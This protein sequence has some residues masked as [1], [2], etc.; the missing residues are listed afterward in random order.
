MFLKQNPQWHKKV[1]LALV[2]V[3]SRVGI[4]E[5][6]ETKEHIEEAVETHQRQV[7][8]AGLGTGTIRRAL[9]FEQVVAL[10][11]TSQVALVTPLRD[12]MNLIAKEYVASR[13]DNAGV[14]ILSE[15]AGAAK[16]LGEALLI[17]PN[18]TDEMAEAIKQ[19]LEMP[20]AEQKLRNAAMQ[21]RLR[22][23]NVVAWAKDFV[24]EINQTCIE[25]DMLVSKVPT[26]AEEEEML[27]AYRDAA[28]RLIMLDYDGTL[29][30]FSSDPQAVKPSERVLD[31][32]AK[33]CANPRNEMVVIERARQA[34]AGSLAGALADGPGGRA[35][36]VVRYWG[37]EWPC[38]SRWAT[39]GSRS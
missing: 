21:K 15:M 35:W 30:A 13:A 6:R 24:R 37:G 9:P 33:L 5:Y 38:R 19:A 25:H 11:C 39:H 17:N 2:V 16:E 31:L 14:L 23:Y 32:L 29:V 12:G 26:D 34:Y 1:V 20:I 8:Q 22:R 36:S 7:R 28:R 18:S 4:G 27:S 10:Y 3:P